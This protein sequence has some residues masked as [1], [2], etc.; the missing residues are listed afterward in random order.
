MKINFDT[1][2]II[3]LQGRI[4]NIF[5]Y[6]K[7]KVARINLAVERKDRDGHQLA[8]YFIQLKSFEPRVYNACQVGMKVKV[9]GYIRPN[10]YEKDGQTIY[11]QDLIAN[12]VEFLEAKQTVEEREKR[13][14]HVA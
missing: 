1:N 3:E 7:G 10:R 13:K 12:F 2:N 6:S 4:S 8:P 9:Y 14:E 11:N 5:E